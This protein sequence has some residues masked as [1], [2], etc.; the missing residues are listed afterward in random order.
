M[1]ASESFRA[2]LVGIGATV[3]LDVWLALL[4]R[5][6][7]QTL[8]IGLIGR[9][10]G[11]AL[12]GQL[13]HPAI[14]KAPP[15][16]GELALGWF[17][18]YA[19]GIVFAGLLFGVTGPAWTQSPSLLPALIVG[20]ATVAAPLFVMQPAMGAGFAASKTPT[21]LKNCIRSTVNHAVFG[22]GLYVSAVAVEWALRSLALTH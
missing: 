3:V 1:L 6:G 20:I 8:S 2:M 21:P 16:R 17:T 7:A 22:I 4:K 9:W 11:H 10:A 12:R 18:H 5:L 19:I 14:A 15:I 13:V